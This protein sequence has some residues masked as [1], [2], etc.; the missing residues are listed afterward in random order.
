MGPI[1]PPMESLF[2]KVAFVVVLLVLLAILGGCAYVIYGYV[3]PPADPA[4]ATATPLPTPLPTPTQ[5][6]TKGVISGL[7]INNIGLTSVDG[8]TAVLQTIE[9]TSFGMN[10]QIAADGSF[11]FSDVP[12]GS[13]Y[14][15]TV[16][17]GTTDTG[18][19]HLGQISGI[20]VTAGQT[21]SGVDVTLIAP[22]PSQEAPVTY[23]YDIQI[24]KN[25]KIAPPPGI[26][27]QFI[28]YDE[29]AG[30]NNYKV[31]LYNTQTMMD[32]VIASGNVRSY[33][34]IGSGKVGLVYMDDNRIMLYDITS[35][36][37]KQS[38]PNKNIPRLYPF[39]FDNK[40]I[41]TGNDGGY[42]PITGW[43][44]IF[45]LYEFEFQDNSYNLWAANVTEPRELRGYG[46]KVVW[47]SP[48]GNDKSIS[49]FDI[50]TCKANVVSPGGAQSDHPRIYG[51]VIV[52]HSIIGGKHHIY[53]YDIDTGHTE[54][55]TN[56][57]KQYSADIYE[58][59]IVY[60]DLRDGNWNIYMYDRSNN[61]ETQLTNEPHDQMSPQ[62][63]GSSIIY[64]DNRNGGWDIYLLR[65]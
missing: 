2:S 7:I 63:Y 9:D 4:L 34:C 55:V 8:I 38:T 59:K 6:P 40:L 52:Y 57:G 16:C 32:E 39:I 54:I 51:S 24:T 17:N 62:I 25:L 49:L 61:R 50:K 18:N 44:D 22:E 23:Q 33:G 64:M 20:S 30:K 41:Y 19:N 36:D 48:S 5:K 26:W 14:Y 60:D 27:E 58:K 11:T 46:N 28:L 15:V 47:W 53:S 13:S 10:A 43:Q 3:S 42:N 21:T 12:E 1:E 65:L 31:H 56:L 29:I 37:M 45:S 35:R